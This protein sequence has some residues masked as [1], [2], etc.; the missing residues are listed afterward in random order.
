[1]GEFAQAC[2]LVMVGLILIHTLGQGG[3]QTGILLSV[4]ICTSLGMLFLGYLKPV[5]EFLDILGSLGG[6]SSQ[7]T[8]T[9]L[10]I[11]GIGILTEI[12][13]MI[14]CDSGSASLGKSLQF[15]GSGVILWL[16]LPL[17]QALIDLLRRILGEL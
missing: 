11:T 16:S 4:V 6:V 5:L 9:L 15:L 8:A 14:C 12:A 10:K 17:F 3:K 7:M 2:G 13:A 1:M